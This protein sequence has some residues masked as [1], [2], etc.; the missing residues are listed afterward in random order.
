[1]TWVCI[2]SVPGANGWRVGGSLELVPSVHVLGWAEVSHSV[3][4]MLAKWFSLPR[5]ET[6]MKVSNICVS[7]TVV[8]LHVQ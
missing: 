4:M 1:M 7:T 2:G 8:H 3:L 5:L 6:R